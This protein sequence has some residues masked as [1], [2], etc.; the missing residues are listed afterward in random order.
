MNPLVRGLL[1]PIATL[2]VVGGSHLLVEAFRPA[3]AEL[4]GP[5]VVMPIHLVAGGWAAYATIRAGG[6]WVHGLIA[7]AILGLLPLVLQVVG[8]GLLLGRDSD[9]VLTLGIF[10]L[11]TIFWGGA[12]GAGI[13][14]ATTP[15]GADASERVARAAA[16]AAR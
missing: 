9:S 16:A 7:G 14:T 1:W 11:F 15:A 4:I 5:A 10:G 8:F 2:L 3:L 6:F 12:L 13:A